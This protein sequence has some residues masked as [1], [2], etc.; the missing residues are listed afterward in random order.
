MNHA[1]FRNLEGVRILE[2][3]YINNI[4]N[5]LS[6]FDCFSKISVLRDP[7]LVQPRGTLSVH[8][9]EARI[10]EFTLISNVFHNA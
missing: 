5:N 4:T 7:V 3:L 8:S 1:S 9:N 6:S 10:S 2:A